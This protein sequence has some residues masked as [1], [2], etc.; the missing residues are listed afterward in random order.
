MP[1]RPPRGP[2]AHSAECAPAVCHPPAS[3]ATVRPD[4]ST[5]ESV[6]APSAGS[7]YSKRARAWTGLGRGA[8]SQRP[9]RELGSTPAGAS[10][11]VTLSITGLSV[12]G[13]RLL[14]SR[15]VEAER[16]AKLKVWCCHPID[17]C[18]DGA[19]SKV[20][21][22]DC[23]AADTR[24]CLITGSVNGSPAIQKLTL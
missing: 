21:S 10:P 5:T 11:T 23:P 1:T 20:K 3:E 12:P 8:A 15:V 13:S 4:R 9:G 17:Q 16:A 14:N 19:L 18:H 7:E 24:R 2:G 22:P 6:A